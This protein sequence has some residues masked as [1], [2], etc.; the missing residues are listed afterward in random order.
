[1]V[2]QSLG[3]LGLGA[4]GGSI[5]WQ[6][7]R[8]GVKRIVGYDV[9]TRYGAAA[10]KAG[11]V[12]EFAQGPWAVA[13]TAD[14]VVIAASE[15]RTHVWLEEV[16]TVLMERE[17]YCTDATGVKR[18]VVALAEQLGLASLFAGSHPLIGVE[19]NGF[20]SANPNVLPGA[21][22]YVTPTRGGDHAAAEVR[23]FWSRVIGASPIALTADQH[24]ALLAWTTHLPQA[25]SSA[26][27]AAFVE[28]GPAGVTYGEGARQVAR[29]ADCHTEQWAELLTTNR[30][31][32]LETLQ[33][34]TESV[35]DLKE[36]L[37]TADRKAV[38]AWLARGATWR[39]RFDQ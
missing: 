36:A 3:V 27:A 25:V 1:M 7:A 26:L 12:T 13:A 19:G 32:V 28:G 21:L 8:S 31:N 18:P 39:A 37:T 20:Q 33:H 35:D 10:V 14:L 17:V 5:A 23:D 29:Y 22:V 9:S 30:D 24:D 16:A 38:E 6:A 4:V 11:A 2:P 15:E 34:L